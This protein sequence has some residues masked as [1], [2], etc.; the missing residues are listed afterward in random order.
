VISG[1]V[2]TRDRILGCGGTGAVVAVATVVPDSDSVLKAT[3]FSALCGSAGCTGITSV[4]SELLMSTSPLRVRL[5]MVLM[6]KLMP[7]GPGHHW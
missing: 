3:T 7:P 2:V 6:L 4:A 1:I 5:L